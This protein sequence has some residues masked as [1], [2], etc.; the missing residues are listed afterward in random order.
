MNKKNLQSNICWQSITQKNTRQRSGIWFYVLPNSI[1][2]SARVFCGSAPFACTLVNLSFA[3]KT[4]LP[5]IYCL[6]QS[7]FLLS[8]CFSKIELNLNI[9][10]RPRIKLF[11]HQNNTIFCSFM[12][13]SKFSSLSFNFSPFQ[14]T[15]L[16]TKSKYIRLTSSSEMI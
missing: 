12:L 1:R 2:R 8:H 3:C 15:L 4:R 6:S 16:Y 5:S 9:I 13:G 11:Q 10:I 14:S 7:P